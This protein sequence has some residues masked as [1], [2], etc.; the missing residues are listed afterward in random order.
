VSGLIEKIE[1]RENKAKTPHLRMQKKKTQLT[2][3][4]MAPVSKLEAGG[5][6]AAKTRGPGCPRHAVTQASLPAGLRSFQAPWG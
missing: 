6:D 5:E 3:N 1:T 2:A 4:H